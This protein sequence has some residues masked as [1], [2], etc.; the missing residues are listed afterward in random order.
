MHSTKFKIYK[1]VLISQSLNDKYKEIRQFDLLSMIDITY[2][3]IV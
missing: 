2:I 1:K 3:T